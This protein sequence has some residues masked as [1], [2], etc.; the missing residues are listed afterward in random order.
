MALCG[1]N[2]AQWLTSKASSVVL[3]SSFG[4]LSAKDRTSGKFVALT[5]SINLE[6]AA[7]LWRVPDPAMAL[8]KEATMSPEPASVADSGGSEDFSAPF[9]TEVITP[10][11]D[12]AANGVAAGDA[13]RGDGGEAV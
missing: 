13:A 10:L 12:T 4:R 9:A 6:K 8:R 3:F 1:S 5:D 7:K 2:S 11:L